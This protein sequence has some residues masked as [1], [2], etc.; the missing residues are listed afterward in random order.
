MLQTKGHTAKHAPVRTG[1]CT[2]INMD[3]LYGPSEHCQVCGT[4]PAI[5]FL[6][7]CNQLDTRPTDVEWEW[8]DEDNHE[9]TKLTLRMELEAIGVSQSMIGAAEQGE[10]T[11][12]QLDMI[13]QQKIHLKQAISDVVEVEQANSAFAML[14]SLAKGVSSTDGTWNDAQVKHEVISP[15]RS[16][17]SMFSHLTGTQAQCMRLQSLP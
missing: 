11:Q 17:T 15:W 10:Y 1:N 14:A 12:T 16:L 13:K 2:H 8:E 4:F 6:Y 9:E 5:G 3:R 7:V